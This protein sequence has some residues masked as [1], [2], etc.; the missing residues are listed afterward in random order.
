MVYVAINHPPVEAGDDVRRLAHPL[1]KVVIV[2]AC[3]HGFAVLAGFAG[4]AERDRLAPLIV[5]RRYSVVCCV[6][7]HAAPAHIFGI[8]Q[9]PTAMIQNVL[10]DEAWMGCME[11]VDF[12]ALTPLIHSHVNP[13]GSFE[14]D[15]GKRLT[16]DTQAA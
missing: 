3:G 6:E 7:F 16:L 2:R 11:P 5:H 15:M 10:A 9:P 8:P 1:G 14:L 13:Y 4:G 12:R